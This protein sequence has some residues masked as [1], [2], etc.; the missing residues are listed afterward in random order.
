MGDGPG[1][2]Y[3]ADKLERAHFT[4]REQQK[5]RKDMLH[6]I[7]CSVGFGET[8]GNLTTVE[9]MAARKLNEAYELLSLIIRS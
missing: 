4:K 9:K 3:M 6:G 1:Y 5:R 7:M 2:D 8:D